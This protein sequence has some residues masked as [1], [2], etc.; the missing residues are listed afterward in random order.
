[1]GEEASQYNI[2][3]TACSHKSKACGAKY[4][5]ALSLED[6]KCV[7]FAGPYLAGVSD[8]ERMVESGLQDLQQSG[9]G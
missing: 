3:T 9:H 4:L 2:D 7:F 1:L 5:I 6:P 8:S